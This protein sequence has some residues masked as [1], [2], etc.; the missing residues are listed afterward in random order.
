M[1][2]LIVLLLSLHITISVAGFAGF[3]GE[4]G[5][6]AAGAGAAGEGAA[7]KAGSDIGEEG[8]TSGDDSSGEDT[9]TGCTVY[10]C[11]PANSGSTTGSSGSSGSSSE[12]ENSAEEIIEKIQDVLDDISSIVSLA[13]ST[14]DSTTYTVTS[15]A[16]LPKAAYP[17]LSARSIY[18][19]CGHGSNFT[20]QVVS[21]QASCLCYQA[22]G[23]KG[24]ATATTTWVPGL[25]DGFV[26]QCNS[27][28]A[29]QTVVSVSA[30]VTGA[31]GATGI[32]ESVGDVRASASAS[33][34]ASPTGR[35]AA[36]TSSSTATP[37]PVAPSTGGVV[38][39]T[40]AMGNGIGYG[41]VL[42]VVGLLM[43]ERAI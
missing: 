10:S 36:A 29:T 7:G 20:D 23:G 5:G 16:P 38:G 35:V 19:A 6:D 27:F 9:D 3:A 13:L 42:L 43:A 1:R 2:L 28:V 24:N 18:S 15:R 34:S 17:C 4:A 39:R 11:P 31:A 14:D 40:S 33:A 37:S 30:S 12:D 8:G 21:E 22:F 25:F 41:G 26:S 32:C